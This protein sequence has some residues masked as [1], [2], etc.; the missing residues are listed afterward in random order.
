MSADEGREHATMGRVVTARSGDPLLPWV[1]PVHS[2]STYR[3]EKS[4]VPKSS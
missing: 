1:T 3:M 2:G 4:A